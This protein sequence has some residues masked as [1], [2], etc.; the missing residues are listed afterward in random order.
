MELPFVVAGGNVNV[1]KKLLLISGAILIFASN[2][3]FAIAVTV[4]GMDNI[5][6]AGLGVNPGVVGPNLGFY[7]KSIDIQGGALISFNSITGTSKY[8]GNV[9][10]PNV[11]PDGVAF[12]TGAPGTA[13]NITSSTGISGITFSGRAMFLVGVF[14]TGSSSAVQPGSITF[15]SGSGG[16]DPDGRQ[17]W[18]TDLAESFPVGQAFYIGD[19]KTGFNN[20]AG[21]TQVWRAPAAATRLF[22][23]FAD[24]GSGGPFVGLFGAYNDNSGDLTVNITQ[25]LAAVPEPGTVLLMGL[26]LLGVGLLRK[27]LA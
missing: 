27:R 11:S 15:V 21:A 16:Y 14:L 4:N 17:D 25:G 6:E 3:L 7:P 5:F 8:G 13:T 22:L 26:G 19:G 24:G 23:G 2:S 10:D 9:A 12:G 18:F 1:M 20:A